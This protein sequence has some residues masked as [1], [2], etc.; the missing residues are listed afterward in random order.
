VTLSPEPVVHTNATPASPGP[1]LPW[2]AWVAMYARLLTVQGA[3]N[4][5]SMMGTGIGF[6]TEPAL[7]SMPGGRSG[8]AYHEALARESRY[9]NAHP[10]LAALAVG[11]LARAEL[12]GR[13]PAQIERFRAALCGPL[14]S[15][16]D[17]LVWAGWLPLS[18]LLA[19]LA[20]GIGASAWLALAIF[21]LVYNVGHLGLRAWA[22]HTGWHH[23]LR[24]AT[25]LGRP[26][27]RQGPA[28][29]SR[30]VALLAGLAVPLALR[31]VIHTTT[32]LTAVAIAAGLLAAAWLVG[33][34][35]RVEGWRFAL[36]VLLALTLASVIR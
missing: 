3:W 9:F 22:L 21:L 4:Y 7:R 11:A 14:G 31:R 35:G 13:P 1:H 29:V 36:V 18:S 32:L 25:A 34:R 17:R 20:F 15:V 8:T 23:G 26:V 27:L 10:Y 16:G 12:E 6:C 33:L 19:L 2:R 30:A 24:V 5:E 28:Y